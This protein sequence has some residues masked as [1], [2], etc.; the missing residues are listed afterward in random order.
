MSLPLLRCYSLMNIDEFPPEFINSQ[1]V[2][3]VFGRL[4]NINEGAGEVRGRALSVTVM[5]R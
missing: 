3:S 2:F 1:G 5:D 4:M